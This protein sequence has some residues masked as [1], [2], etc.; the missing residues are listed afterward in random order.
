MFLAANPSGITTYGG[1]PAGHGECRPV[2]PSSPDS[3][4]ISSSSVDSPDMYSSSLSISAVLVV[5][6][7]G[8]GGAA[9]VDVAC[10]ADGKRE[11][12]VPDAVLAAEAEMFFFFKV[13]WSS[14]AV[15]A[16]AAFRFLVR[17]GMVAVFGWETDF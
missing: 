3:S 14:G 4:A 2:I 8:V 9:V 6:V 10:L 7:W 13:G 12:A 15:D 1:V 17:G 5:V 16:S 11:I